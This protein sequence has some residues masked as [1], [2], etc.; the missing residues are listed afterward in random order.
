M[1]GVGTYRVVIA[2]NASGDGTVDVAN[3]DDVEHDVE[4]LQLGGNLGYSAGINAVTSHVGPKGALLVLNPDIRLAAGSV[5]HLLEGLR[6]PGVGITVPRMLRPDGSLDPSLAYEP[7][8][9]RGLAE[10]VLGG[11]LS[12]RLA[13]GER[14]R[15]PASYETDAV[16]D[17]ASGAAWLISEPC[18]E[19]VGPWDESFFIYAEEIDYGLR[20]RDAGFDT[21][22]A[23]DAIAVHLRGGGERSPELRP[24]Q[25]FNKWRVYRRRHSAALGGVYRGVLALNEALRLPLGAEYLTS[26]KTVG[27]PGNPPAQLVERGQLQP[28]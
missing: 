27:L 9:R 12:G 20:A 10:A 14:D 23:P 25:V 5:A 28:K 4:V 15:R 19:G 7:C 11:R 26:L 3:S 8:I 22:L 1:E 24:L 13:L 2:D 16:A 18:R 17:W 6:R 21:R